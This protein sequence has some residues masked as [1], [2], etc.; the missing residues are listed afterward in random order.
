VSPKKVY[1]ECFGCQMNAFDSEVLESMLEGEGFGI[2]GEPDSADAILVNTCSVR[3]NAETRAIGRLNDLSRHE[4]AV[5]A[6]CG[7]M[8]QRLGDRLFELVPALD[9]VAGPDSYSD[10]PA[11][12][13]AALGGDGR[14]LL[15][16]E[17]SSVTYRLESSRGSSPTRYLSITR[18]CENYC[19]YCIV[20]YVRGSVRSKSPEA[21]IE[22]IGLLS[23]SGAR[24]VTL[25]GQN[26][27]AWTSG[28][29]GFTG[30]L[31]RILSETDIE[32][33]RFL[34][35]HP[36]DVDDDI[37]R[38][39]ADEPR[40]CPHIHLP[41][42][43]GSDRILEAMNR[44]YTRGDY[45][46]IVERARA[47]RPDIAFTTDIIVGFPGESETDFS[48]TLDIVER[49]RFDSAF[50]FKYSPREGTAAAGLEDDVPL[51]E[52]KS[53]LERL[54]S[55][56]QEIRREIM[57]DLTGSVE[58]ILLDAR[59]KKGETHFLKGR[60]PHFRNVLLASDNRNPGD[61]LSVVLKELSNFTF[62]GEETTGR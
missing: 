34:T 40:I 20:P 32:R 28:G 7:C 51:E 30:L 21:V 29:D 5:L 46:A 53:R 2:A 25:L 48:E 41:F 8:A 33:V 42:Q 56:I 12:I 9:I 60:T 45:L 16:E 11:A 31:R 35:T 52:K 39:M 43:A 18:G 24:E 57:E 19:S 13:S 50:T 23:R 38:L 49:V 17:D 62:I 26:V 6:V 10:L 14:K 44:G 37:F 36:R 61:I 22:D 3:E 4:H 59:V 55:R 1:L 58:E 47:I 15:L 27:M 54:N